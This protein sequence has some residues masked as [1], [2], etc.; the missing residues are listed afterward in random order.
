MKFFTVFT[1]I[2]SL[3]FFIVSPIVLLNLINNKN[4]TEK[5]VG[6]YGGI[7]WVVVFILLVFYANMKK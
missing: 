3:F 6:I 4:S 5:N 2:V 7:T 1:I